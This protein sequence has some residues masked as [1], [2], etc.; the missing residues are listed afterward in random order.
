MAIVK[1][2]T[3]VG[4]ANVAVVI[5]TNSVITP[6]GCRDGGRIP[7][8]RRIPQQWDE[9]D[10][11]IRSNTW[12]AAEFVERGKEIDQVSGSITATTLLLRRQRDN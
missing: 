10:A 6:S 5:R 1:F 2:L 4:V 3:T 11:L 7:V 9:A 12:K 8:V